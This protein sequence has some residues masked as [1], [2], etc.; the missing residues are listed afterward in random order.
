MDEMLYISMN[1]ARQIMKAQSVNTNN[2]ANV[3]TTGFR[4]DLNAFSSVEVK[5]PGFGSRVY[6]VNGGNGIDLSPGSIMQTGRDLDIAISG[7]GYIAVQAADG[8]EAYTRA[9]NF[10]FNAAGQLMTGSGNLVMGNSGPVSLPPFEKLEIGIDGTLS[11]RPIGQSAA[12]LAVVDRIK[13]V[14]IPAQELVKNENGLLKIRS[15]EE[16][17]ADA[18]VKVVSGA[19]EGSNVSA[20][21]SMVTMIDLSRAFE[22][23]IKIMTTA[24]ETAESAQTLMRVS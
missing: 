3:S 11:I 2:L 16:A 4:A 7:E 9:G 15:G 22:M 5:G 24:N 18:A 17:L 13:L 8:T 6:G 12:T 10:S 19:L 21:E 20:I 1:G 14:N 23:Q